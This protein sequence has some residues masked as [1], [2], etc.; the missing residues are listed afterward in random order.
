MYEIAYPLSL[1][2]RETAIDKYA[3]ARCVMYYLSEGRKIQTI[4]RGGNNY[5]HNAYEESIIKDGEFLD[6]YLNLIKYTLEVSFIKDYV[7]GQRAI[8]FAYK[9]EMCGI[10]TDFLKEYYPHLDIRR[11]VAE[12]PI[13]NMNDADIRVTTLGS[14]STA[15][16][17]T[18]LKTAILTVNVSSLQSNIQAF[19]RLRKIDG[20]ITRFYYLICADIPKHM[21]YHNSKVE[22]FSERALNFNTIQPPFSV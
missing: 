12:D 15:H 6:S 22:I 18:N 2:M 8:I 21:E 17:I 16:D 20:L 13:E 19:G 5:S 3:I 9:T 7:K 11:Y 4:E 10:I 1:R 14:G